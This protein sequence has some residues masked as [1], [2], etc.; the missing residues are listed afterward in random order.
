MRIT[1]GE[2][3]GKILCSFKGLSIR[4]TSDQI[5]EAIFNILGQGFGGKRVLD[6][7]AGTGSL[8]LEALSR[9]ATGAV[10]ID[11]SRQAIALI[12]KNLEICGFAH[13]AMVFKRDLRKRLP[14]LNSMGGAP[15]HGVFLDPPYRQG[16]VLRTLERLVER[17]TLAKDAVVMAETYKTEDLPG[18]IEGLELIDQRV[19]GDTKINFF[20]WRGK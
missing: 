12:R 13:R 17:G 15:F 4:P 18:E 9:G 7:F 10:F 6:L 11:A 5:R 8:G 16:L 3:R 20:H 2:A 14:T 1:G 19:Y